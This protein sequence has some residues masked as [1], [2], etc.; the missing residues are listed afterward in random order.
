MTSSICAGA[1][2]RSEEMAMS[3]LS[4]AADGSGRGRPTVHTDS[5]RTPQTACEAKKASAMG[6][7]CR[8]ARSRDTQH[9]RGCACRCYATSAA[10]CLETDACGA[11]DKLKIAKFVWAG[12][13]RWGILRRSAQANKHPAQMCAHP[14][15]P[16]CNGC[17]CAAAASTRALLLHRRN[18]ALP[19]R[20]VR[21]R[22]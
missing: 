12:L 19:T 11:K 2:L 9:T 14:A 20:R 3:R 5:T 16:Q 4:R 7:P 15:S 13:A 1:H 22:L 21:A 18:L 17:G 10:Y 6:A 8:T